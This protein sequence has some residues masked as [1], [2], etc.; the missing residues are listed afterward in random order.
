MGDDE[1]LFWLSAAATYQTK[2][3]IYSRP[4]DCF[5]SCM[6]IHTNIM[7]ILCMTLVCQSGRHGSMIVPTSKASDLVCTYKAIRVQRNETSERQCGGGDPATY[8]LPCHVQ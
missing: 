7:M 4:L 8:V 2:G 1:V 6:C 5:V 3:M